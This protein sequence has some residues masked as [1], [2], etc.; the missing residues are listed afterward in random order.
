MWQGEEVESYIFEN[1]ELVAEATKGY[2]PETG[3]YHQ[4]RGIHTFILSISS[5]GEGSKSMVY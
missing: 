2:T 5:G 3:L 4:D 1:S